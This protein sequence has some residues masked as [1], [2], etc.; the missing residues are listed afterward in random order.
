[1]RIR[2]S[3]R[4]CAT[5][6]GAVRVYFAI[7]A[8]VLDVAENL[9]LEKIVTVLVELVRRGDQ[10]RQPM[11]GM[12]IQPRLPRLND[13]FPFSVSGYLMPSRSKVVISH[14]R[15]LISSMPA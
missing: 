5:V 9:L 10:W 13:G 15:P 11:L 12:L 1:M 14:L 8:T 2:E 4:A 3:E 7:D 6:V